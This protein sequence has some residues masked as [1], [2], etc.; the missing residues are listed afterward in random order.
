VFGRGTRLDVVYVKHPALGVFV[1]EI[2]G[3]PVQSRPLSRRPNPLPR[4]LKWI[5]PRRRAL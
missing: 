1:V 3:V 2:D 5:D 4:R